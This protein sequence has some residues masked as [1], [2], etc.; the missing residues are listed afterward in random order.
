MDHNNLNGWHQ[1]Y[2]ILSTLNERPLSIAA[3]MAPVSVE[4]SKPEETAESAGIPVRASI[5]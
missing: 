3:K 5:P 2:L 1:F 4:N